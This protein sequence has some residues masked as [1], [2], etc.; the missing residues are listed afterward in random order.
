VEGPGCGEGRACGLFNLTFSPKRVPN[1]AMCIAGTAPTPADASAAATA[2]REAPHAR[3][4][5]ARLL[6]S[7]SMRLRVDSDMPN[8]DLTSAFDMPDAQA[9]S[10]ASTNG[11]E[12]DL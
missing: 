3:S 11:S 7:A 6:E 1:A 9:W 4:A 10:T 12:Y 8:D 2:A 5:H